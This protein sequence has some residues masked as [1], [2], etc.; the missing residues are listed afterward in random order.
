MLDLYVQTFPT[1]R[2]RIV[3]LSTMVVV[4]L[5]FIGAITTTLRICQPIAYNWDSRI[6]GHCG[7]VATA[8]LIAAAFNLA[9]DIFIV[10]L[11]V[12]TIWGLRMSVQKKWAVTTTFGLGLW[13][14]S[15]FSLLN[16]QENHPV[17]K[18]T[19]LL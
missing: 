13:C 17:E 1:P 4:T 12:S 7:D 3:A 2:F 6:N 14:V 11:P 15:S 18:C 10:A 5:F 19:D 16:K 8:E 9:L